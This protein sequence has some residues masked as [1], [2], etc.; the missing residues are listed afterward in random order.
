MKIKMIY[1]GFARY[2][3]EYW[4]K[5][6][7]EETYDFFDCDFEKHEEK[8]IDYLDDDWECEHPYKVYNSYVYYEFFTDCVTDNG[9]KIN[10]IINT[11][12]K[13]ISDTKLN[14][15]DIVEIECRESELEDL[16]I[17]YNDCKYDKRDK[18]YQLELNG[19][20]YITRQHIKIKDY[21]KGSFKVIGKEE[22]TTKEEKEIVISNNETNI[23]DKLYRYHELLKYS[24]DA[25]KNHTK[26]IMKKY[27]IN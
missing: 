11:F 8:R 23:Y 10:L 4:Y 25:C 5:C 6:S 16:K 15:G 22:T 17:F 18:Y 26:E 21:V 3:N 24:P 14:I 1:R 9:D 2:N 20:S 12:S 7:E 13:D 27:N 19:R